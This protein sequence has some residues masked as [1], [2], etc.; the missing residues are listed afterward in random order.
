MT[1]VQSNVYGATTTLGRIVCSVAPSDVKSMV[2]NEYR[3]IFSAFF[4]NSGLCLAILDRR[5][6]V[7]D[8]N[9][10]LLNLLGLRPSE[11]YRHD[12]P[13]LVHPHVRDRIGRQLSRL[14]TRSERGFQE[15]FTGLVPGA[16]AKPVTMIATAL[17]GNEQ[18]IA[19]VLLVCVPEQ[20]KRAPGRSPGKTEVISEIEAKILQGIAAG[21]S[22][23]DLAGKLYLSRQGVEYHIH[24]MMR[25]FKVKNRTA[26]VS[27]AYAVGLLTPENW[28][29]KVLPERC[30]R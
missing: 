8:A 9:G 25:R 14:A 10:D 2:E 28:P 16:D 22:T 11:V 15:R 21:V 17:P 3:N 19:A 27:R 4:D 29:P 5:L 12:F 26:L 1:N 23:V 18:S 20:R 7:L 6:R 30:A 13:D 24:S